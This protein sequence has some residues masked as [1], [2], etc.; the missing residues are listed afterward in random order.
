MFDHVIHIPIA[1]AA[2]YSIFQLLTPCCGHWI[3]IGIGAGFL[4]VGIKGFTAKGLPIVRGKNLAG[5]AGKIV[6]SICLL[7]GIAIILVT[8]LFGIVADYSERSTPTPNGPRSGTVGAVGDAGTTASAGSASQPKASATARY[9]S[10][11]R[12]FALNFAPDVWTKLDKQP[13]PAAEVAFV[14]KIGGAYALIICE[15][16]GAPLTA[17]RDAA[18][19]NAKNVDR[20]AEVVKEEKKVVNGN[21]GLC[22]TINAR[23]KGIEFTYYIYLYSGGGRCIQAMTW[24]GQAAFKETKAELDAFLNG[25]EVI[26][27]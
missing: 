25:F 2:A 15:Q 13:F 21:E 9:E 7:V 18:V 10:P 19:Q 22:L 26:K 17:L 23:I 4:F 6:G 16:L 12:A 3:E 11:T 14:N 20:E 24:T 1:D 8:I 5:S 27:Q